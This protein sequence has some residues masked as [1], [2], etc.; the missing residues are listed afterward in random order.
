MHDQPTACV[1][2]SEAGDPSTQLWTAKFTKKTG[3][4]T[5]LRLYWGWN[6]RG[7]WE[8]APAP[9][10]QYRGEPFLYKL[11]VSRDISQQPNLAPQADASADFLRRFVPEMR[12]TLFE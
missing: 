10:W 2:K 12:K 9:R 8:A 3:E 6:A 11:Y 1:I 7:E 4:T 5:N